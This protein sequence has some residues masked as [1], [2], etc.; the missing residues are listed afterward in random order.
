MAKRMT[1]TDKWDKEW[2]MQQPPKIKCL[3]LYLN[4]KCDQAGVWDVNFSLASMYIGEQIT[5]TDLTQFGDRVEKIA[6]GKIWI[7]DHVDFQCGDLSEK[8]P[9]HKPVYKLLKK[10]SLLDRVLNR[11]YN[12]QQEK[13]KEK[14]IELDKEMEKENMSKSEIFDSLFND[15]R[16]IEQLTMTHKGKDLKQAFE[17]C[18]THHSNTPRPPHDMHEWRRKLNTWLTIKSGPKKN[19]FEPVKKVKLDDL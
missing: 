1:S 2:F 9:A 4:D 19:G 3:W 5:E 11:V 8:C 15:Q 18:Y 16:Y 12:T 14:E 13:E 7:V 10:Y 17:E 6:P